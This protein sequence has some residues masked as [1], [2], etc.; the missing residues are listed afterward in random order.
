MFN[1]NKQ[2]MASEDKQPTGSGSIVSSSTVMIGN[3]ES[4]DLLRIEGKVNGDILKAPRVIVG[5]KGE[6]HGNIT[7]GQ[8][9]VEG[10][11]HGNI[12]CKSKVI[13]KS[14]A[15]ITGEVKAADLKVE[16]GALINGKISIGSQAGAV[17]EK[18]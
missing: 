12:A 15:K 1:S 14:T 11:I 8:L 10:T 7:C 4:N 13:C 17:V 2:N 9:D 6:I 18:K 5:S 3:I 16:A